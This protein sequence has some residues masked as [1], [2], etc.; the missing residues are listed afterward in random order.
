MFPH[1][2]HWISQHEPHFPRCAR[3]VN[4]TTRWGEEGG[5]NERGKAQFHQRI[6]FAKSWRDT[7]L[8]R[9]DFS[10]SIFNHIK[11]VLDIVGAI[12]N[13][14]NYDWVVS[15]RNGY[16][17]PV[18]YCSICLQWKNTR[19]LTSSSKES[20]GAIVAYSY[21]DVRTND[22]KISNDCDDKNM[23]NIRKHSRMICQSLDHHQSKVSH[24]KHKTTIQSLYCSTTLSC[25]LVQPMAFAHSPLKLIDARHRSHSLFTFIFPLHHDA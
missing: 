2:A 24:H 19:A 16:S 21:I 20:S 18:E 7:R 5:D 13:L 1:D 6:R 11:Y 22:T 23:C 8:E 14:Y 10:A 17:F 9:Y 12:S 4:F 15:R 25:D 3:V